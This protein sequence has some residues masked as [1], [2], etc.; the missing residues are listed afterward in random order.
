MPLSV[1]NLRSHEGYLP[2]YLP[3][4]STV[5]AP[6]HYG[7]KSS[8]LA[9]Y[10]GDIFI[11]KCLQPTSAFVQLLYG[12]DR[13]HVTKRIEVYCAHVTPAVARAYPVLRLPEQ[14]TWS[15]VKQ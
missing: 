13:D 5:L 9:S 1:I 6:G 8:L 10:N 14:D 12:H 15:D 11:A 3:S 4:R 2:E 7:L